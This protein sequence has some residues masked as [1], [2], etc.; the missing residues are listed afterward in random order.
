MTRVTTSQIGQ[1]PHDDAVP[2]VP[3]N[4]WQLTG[5]IGQ[6][7]GEARDRTGHSLLSDAGAMNM[8]EK[9]GSV[10]HVDAPMLL[11]W[12]DCAA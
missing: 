3:S 1:L 9:G 10:H 4:P 2:Y 7:C 6:A 8:G 12:V 5:T 11:T